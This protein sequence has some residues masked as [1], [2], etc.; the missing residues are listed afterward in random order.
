MKKYNV[1][2]GETVWATLPIE[3]ESAEEAR[4]KAE[5]EVAKRREYDEEIEGRS[6]SYK[7]GDI[8]E[9]E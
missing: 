7:I 4:E 3:A 6:T 1:Q 9:R 5:R 8:K 2:I